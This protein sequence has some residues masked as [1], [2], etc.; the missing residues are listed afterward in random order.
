MRILV[1]TTSTQV[2]SNGRI[3]P[4]VQN[5]GPG[6]VYI[7]TDGDVDSTSGLQIPVGAVYE[8]PLS[9]G[10]SNIWLVSTLA[11]TDVRVVGMGG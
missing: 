1:G 7:D 11:N 3:R 8:F 10:D 9:G 2:A 4:V 6:V 5:L